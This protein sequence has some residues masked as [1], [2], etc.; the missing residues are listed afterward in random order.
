MLG[1]MASTTSPRW[2]STPVGLGAL[3]TEARRR[4]GYS[5]GRLAG[6]LNVSVSQLQGVEEGRRPPSTELAERLCDA[7]PLD[8][9]GM[10]VV[11]ACAVDTGALKAR[12]G[13]R[14]VNGRGTPLPPAV[15][16][17]I[18]A[19]RERGRSLRAIAA[20]LARDGVPTP[21]GGQ[22]WMSTVRRILAA[23]QGRD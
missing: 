15:R 19:E 22:W 18:T 21:C 6:R 4:T 7:L 13:V 14:H 10:A 20:G 9:W 8:A 11:L 5:R 17:R 16:A 2:A 12:R 3:L 1:G 23:D